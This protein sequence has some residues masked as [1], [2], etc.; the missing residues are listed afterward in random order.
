MPGHPRLSS[1]M[2]ETKDVDARHE[3]GHDGFLMQVPAGGADHSIPRVDLPVEIAQ[4]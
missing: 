1:R 2:S 3:A 4:V